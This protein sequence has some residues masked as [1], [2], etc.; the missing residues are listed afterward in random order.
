MPVASTGSS[1][2]PSARTKMLVAP[3]G[4]GASAV[5]V[6]A[7]ALTVSLIVPSPESTATMWTPSDAACAASS[8]ACPRPFVSATSSRKSADSAFSITASTGFE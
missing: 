6:P 3:P 5:S 8:R 7:N 2:N 1:G 4:S